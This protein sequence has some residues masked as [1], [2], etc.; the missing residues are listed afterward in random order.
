M[1]NVNLMSQLADMGTS[2]VCI[3]AYGLIR[4]DSNK[5]G[6]TL[7]VISNERQ[8]WDL[9]VKYGLKSA[10]YGNGA[11]REISAATAAE[12]SPARHAMYCPSAGRLDQPAGTDSC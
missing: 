2:I 3:R 8:I 6:K 5:Q 10:L 1:T 4:Y 12:Q 9:T 7:H 11:M